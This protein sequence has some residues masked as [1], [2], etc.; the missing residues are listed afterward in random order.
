MEGEFRLWKAKWFREKKKKNSVS[1]TA[2][3]ALE[4]CD[5]IVSPTIN[6]LLRILAP[7]PASVDSVD[8]TD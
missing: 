2:L 7:L 8:Y 6:V 5:E 3:E 4:D 1:S